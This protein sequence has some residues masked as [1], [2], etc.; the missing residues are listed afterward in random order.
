MV[1]VAVKTNGNMFRMPAMVIGNDEGR[2]IFV[3]IIIR[4]IITDFPNQAIGFNNAVKIVV[5]FFLWS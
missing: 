4:K 3:K 5:L 2:L 1:S